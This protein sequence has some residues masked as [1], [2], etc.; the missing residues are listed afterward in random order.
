MSSARDCLVCGER[1]ETATIPGLLQCTSCRFVTADV[2][3][4]DE[5]LQKLYGEKYFQGE[6]YRDYASERHLFEKQFH[7]RLKTLLRYAPN[8]KEKR[9]FEIGAAYGF[10]LAKAKSYFREVAGIDI[11]RE[12]VAHARNVVGV[13]V[14]A[15]DFLDLEIDGSIDVLCLWDT[16]EHLATPHLYLEKAASH[17]PVGGLVAITTGDIDSLLARF[18]GGQWRQIHPP[19]HLHYFSRRTLQKL[20]EKLGFQLRYSGYDGCYR[21]MDTIAYIVLALKRGN[22]RAYERL[23]KTGLLNWSFYSNFFDIMY[24]IAEKRR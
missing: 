4:T 13:N 1:Y 24:L 16:I 14:A 17:M 10:F 8:A 18:R 19:T 2:S 7:R 12:A 21:S 23:K 20:L 3:L 11:S 5:E 9:L 22:P 15:G 6:E